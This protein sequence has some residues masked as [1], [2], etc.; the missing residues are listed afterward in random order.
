MTVLSQALLYDLTGVVTGQNLWSAN[1]SYW[2]VSC[3]STKKQTVHDTFDRDR[4][5]PP[6][7]NSIKICHRPRD[8]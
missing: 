4:Y 6:N 1:C 8:S 7:N 2:L 3:Y 5:S